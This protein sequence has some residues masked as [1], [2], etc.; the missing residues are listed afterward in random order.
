MVQLIDAG[1]DALNELASGFGQP[2]PTRL[3]LE[4]EDAKVFLQC[5]HAG[6]D[7][8]LRHAGRIGGVAEVQILGDVECL[9]ERCHRNAPARKRG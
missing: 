9:V 3:A 7:V 4:Q 6:A 2:D 8:G 5:L 1:S